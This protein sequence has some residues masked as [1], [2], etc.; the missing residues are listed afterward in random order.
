MPTFTEK[1][2]LSAIAEYGR[3]LDDSAPEAEVHDFLASH[4]YFWNNILRL[5]GPCPLYSK[6]K[7]GNEHE[8]DFAFFDAGSCGAE[9]HLVEIERPSA[10]L[11]NKRGDPSADLV[12]A[13]AQVRTWQRW[14]EKHREYADRLMPGIDAPMGHVFIGRRAELQSP[15]ARERLRAYNI[16]HRMHLEVH[17]LDSFTR[18]AQSALTYRATPLPQVALRD[19]DL[20]SG[21]PEN[22]LYFVQSG[23]GRQRLFLEDRECVSHFDEDRGWSS[24]GVDDHAVTLIPW[25]EDDATG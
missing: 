17:T 4:L 2:I 24:G 7:L 15:E 21:L 9:W 8:I 1:E 16:E 19:R 22:A 18:G 25:P 14:I 10:R 20:R 6:I 5:G 3:L 12:H 23:F 11:F 13:V